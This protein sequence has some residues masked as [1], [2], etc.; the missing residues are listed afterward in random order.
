MQLRTFTIQ[1]WISNSDGYRNPQC[2]H[3]IDIRDWI[4]DIHDWIMDIHDWIVDIHIRIMAIHNNKNWFMDSIEEWIFIRGLTLLPFHGRSTFLRFVNVL[5]SISKDHFH[6]HF[7]RDGNFIL[8]KLIFWSSEH[9]LCMPW[10]HR[11]R[12]SYAKISAI[13]WSQFE[14]AGPNIS[15]YQLNLNKSKTNCSKNLNSDGMIVREMGLGPD[16]TFRS[17]L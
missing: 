7:Q 15:W 17:L 13:G 6:S 11:S 12:V 4:M 1:L 5:R 9:N 10:K 14:L 3:C 2:N 8:S 16:C